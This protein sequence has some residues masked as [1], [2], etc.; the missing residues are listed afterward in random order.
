MQSKRI[1]LGAYIKS[2]ILKDKFAEIKKDFS[3]TKGAWV[4]PNI[5]HFTFK[6]FGE[7]DMDSFNEIKAVSERFTKEYETEMIFKG[8]GSF[9]NFKNPKVLFTNLINK[10]KLLA[11]LNKDMENAF[12]ELGFAPDDKAFHPHITLL[13]IKSSEQEKFMSAIDKYSTFDF[14]KQTTLR[15]NLIESKLMPNGPIY[16]NIL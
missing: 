3:S 8:L 9:P 11:T 7:V 2:D 1:F 10:D 12:S 14:G 5:F 13:R 15:V 16:K 6:F 4:N